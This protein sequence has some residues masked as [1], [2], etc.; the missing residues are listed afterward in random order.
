M[1][2]LHGSFLLFPRMASAMQGLS[3]IGVSGT[4]AESLKDWLE[5][6]I[7]LVFQVN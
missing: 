2:L 6:I 3:S 1:K 7:L 5:I 4:L